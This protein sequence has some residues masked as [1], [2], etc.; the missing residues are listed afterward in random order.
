MSVTGRG[1]PA[2]SATVDREVVVSRR[3]DAPPE[4]VFEAFTEIRHVS[5]WWEP[6]R[7]TTTTRSFEFRVGEIWDFVMHRRTVRTIPNGS[8]GPRFLR[9][10]GS[11]CSTV[12][13]AVTR[14]RSVEDSHV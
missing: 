6:E 8:R 7:F 9:R 5:R 13:P 2:Q 1:A 10:V 3:I 14:T 12:S 4:L 11:R